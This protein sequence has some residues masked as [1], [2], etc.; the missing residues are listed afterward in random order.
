[1]AG[2]SS[3]PRAGWHLAVPFVCAALAG[4]GTSGCGGG[5]EPVPIGETPAEIEILAGNYQRLDPGATAPVNL[6]VRVTDPAGLPVPRVPIEWVVEGGG[7]VRPLNRSTDIGGKVVA[8]LTLTSTISI[9]TVTARVADDTTLAVEFT[10]FGGVGV[11]P[12]DQPD[13]EILI[14]MTGFSPN[15]V[16]VPLQGVV[17]WR[18]AGDSPHN[19]RFDHPDV[20]RLNYRIEGV[21]DIVFVEP[22]DYSYRCGGHTNGSGFVTVNEY[23]EHPPHSG[24]VIVQ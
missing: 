10:I 13:A 24:R 14:Q 8:E 2:F 23:P 17:R 20:P 15:L 3:I 4:L 1:M 21:R 22:G 19:V 6:E 11:R 9:R 12:P 5:T 7:V 18:W 16:S